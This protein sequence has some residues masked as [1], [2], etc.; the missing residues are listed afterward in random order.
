MKPQFEA[1]HVEASKGRG[2]VT[3]PAVWRDAMTRCASAIERAAAGIIGVMA[4]PLRGAAGNAE[5][6]IGAALG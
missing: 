6:F 3:D 5:F 2:V 4:S 1:S